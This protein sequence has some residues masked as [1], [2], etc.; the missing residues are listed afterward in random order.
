MSKFKC[1]K[2]IS[3]ELTCFL[4]WWMHSWPNQTHSPAWQCWSLGMDRM[5][6][7][8]VKKQSFRAW[9]TT[10]QWVSRTYNLLSH[11]LLS[12]FQFSHLQFLKTPPTNSL[13]TNLMDP[14]L[15]YNEERISHAITQC[16][17]FGCVLLQIHLSRSCT[18]WKHTFKRCHV[19]GVLPTVLGSQQAALWQHLR[20][21][22]IHLHFDG[23][24]VSC[25]YRCRFSKTL[26]YCWS[27]AWSISTSKVQ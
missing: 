14:H 5:E 16:V 24:V 10:S 1:L 7:S 8:K 11:F 26:L 3:I 15:D 20:V 21:S 13:L 17:T 27:A 25:T 4:V 19:P 2:M 9:P 6:R 23:D 18:A 22:G 12:I